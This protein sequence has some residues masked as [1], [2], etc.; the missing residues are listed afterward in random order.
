MVNMGKQTSGIVLGCFSPP[1]MVATFLLESIMAAYTVYKY[2]LSNKGRLI[3]A[4][5]L[6]LAF[7]QAAEYFV[8]TNSTIAVNSSRFGYASI[9]LLPA[10]GLYLMSALSVPMRKKAV[11]FMFTVSAMLMAYF[12]LAPTAFSGYQCTGNYVIFQ[13][14]TSQMRLYGT[15]YYGLIAL[16][17]F[18]GTKFLI[19]NPKAKRNVRLPVQWLMTGYLVFIV[20]VAVL[21]V[22]HPDTRRAIPSILCGFAVSLAVILAAKMAPLSLK[23]R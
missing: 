12:L 2:K 6:S 15:Y 1:V 20:P 11:I 9:T 14:G 22:T 13:I 19:N 4:L 7:F 17:L 18:K 8:C 10:L 5:M 16:A 23:K 3:L 21:L